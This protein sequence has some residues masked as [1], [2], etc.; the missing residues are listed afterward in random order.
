MSETN[1][2]VTS[3]LDKKPLTLDEIVES[4]VLY[5]I[6]GTGFDRDRSLTIGVLKHWFE[7]N[8][9]SLNIN[10]A[11][12]NVVI[13]GHGIFFKARGTDILHISS[14]SAKLHWPEFFG[15]SVFH[16]DVNVDGDVQVGGNVDFNGPVT[17]R[18]ALEILGA[19]LFKSG[20]EVSGNA[21]FNGN[22]E[23]VGKVYCDDDLVVEKGI[24]AYGKKHF[25]GDG[26]ENQVVFN[27]GD[28]F[29][30]KAVRTSGEVSGSTLVATDFLK[31]R[32]FEAASEDELKYPS[33]IASVSLL[34]GLTTGATILVKNATTGDVEIV[35]SRSGTTDRMVLFIKKGEC[36]T[37][38]YDGANWQHVW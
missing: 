24:K 14:D 3:V 34:G 9:L 30:P 17:F 19:V 12:V 7:T 21:K 35:R 16:G 22:A 26:S 37:F 20:I 1:G 18:K 31:L 29:V 28:V 32:V 15:N 38:V 4:I 2:N 5:A 13:D 23:V 36:L 10:A 27:Q 11:D 33:K 25:F 8:L 6:K